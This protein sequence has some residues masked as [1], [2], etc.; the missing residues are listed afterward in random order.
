MFFWRAWPAPVLL[1][2]MVCFSRVGVRGSAVGADGSGVGWGGNEVG[3]WELNLGNEA[4]HLSDRSLTYF[5][6]HDLYLRSRR[7]S[8]VGACYKLLTWNL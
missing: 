1:I 5:D 2:D 8:G 3:L 6:W 7:T 4:V